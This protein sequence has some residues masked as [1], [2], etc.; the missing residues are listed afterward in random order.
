MPVSRVSI[1]LFGMNRT[2][3]F[4]DEAGNLVLSEAEGFDFS[5]NV[6]ATNYFILTTVTMPDC[7]IDHELLALK[8]QLAWE[9]A[10]LSDYFHATEDKQAIRNR[11]YETIA[12]TSFRIDATILEKPKA[13]PHLRTDD[14]TFYTTCVVFSLQIFGPADS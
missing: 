4:A 1:T 6:G 14:I 2:Y 5:R 11:V 7:S 13:A 8:R 3:V 12:Q 9:G 10:E